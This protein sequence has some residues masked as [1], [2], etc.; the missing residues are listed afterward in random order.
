MQVAAV[1]V[2]LWT[3]VA[4]CAAEPAD[5][6]RPAVP[7][8]APVPVR[9]AVV[10]P[11][12]AA[13]PEATTFTEIPQAPVDQ[14]ADQPASGVLLRIKRDTAVHSA[15]GGAP[16]AKL[17]PVQLGNPTWVPVVEQ[18]GEWAR[19]LLPS[20]PNGS[21]GWVWTGS[22]AEVEKARSPYLVDVDIDARRLRVFR[23]GAQV[24]GWTVGV[25]AE[26]SPTPRGRTYIMAAIEETVTNFSPVILPLGTHSNTYTT[27]GGGPGTVALHTWPDPAVFGQASS[28]GCVRV[29]QEALQFLAT[30]PLGTLVLLR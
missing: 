30:L 9:P 29:P 1:L 3:A 23:D 2:A 25:G 22:G 18:Q 17:P 27:Y 14:A 26:E 19:V 6:A 13:L 11:D 12:L 16:F 4:G 21:T 10:E 20:R 7:R 28:D 5:Q 15:P 24:G 8:S